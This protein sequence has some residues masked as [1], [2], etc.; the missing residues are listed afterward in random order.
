MTVFVNPYQELRHLEKAAETNKEKKE[1]EEDNMG[2]WFTDPGG[3]ARKSKE[4]QETL[5]TNDGGVGKYLKVP[6][7]SN[8]DFNATTSVPKGSKQTPAQQANKETKKVVYG[9]FDAW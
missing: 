1:S 7:A 8:L 4:C 9:N 6:I 5:K 2:L 3:G